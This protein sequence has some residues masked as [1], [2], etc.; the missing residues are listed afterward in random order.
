MGFITQLLQ[1]THGQWIYW[2]LLVHDHTSGILA[3]LHKTELLEEIANQLL[4]GANT[5][6]RMIS[7]F[8]NAT[9]RT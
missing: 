4:M 3:I 7:I 5:L 2:C 6:W 1:V 8:W 9:F